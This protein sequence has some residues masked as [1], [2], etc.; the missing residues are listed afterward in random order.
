V[1]DVTAERPR[2]ELE[3]ERD[4]LL[5]S[6]SDLEREHLAGDVD[7]ED[8]ESL[9]ADYVARAAIAIRA[10]ETRP[11]AAERRPTSADRLSRIRRFL[12]RPTTRRSL[13]AVGVVCLLL[14]VGLL[15]A[16]LAGVR[17]PGES[18]TGS[19]SLPRAT[20]IRDDLAAASLFA[21][22]GRQAEAVGLYDA[23]LELDPRQ[24]V[25]LADRGWLERLA[26]LK[27][28]SHKAVLIGDASIALAVAV[29]PGYPDAHA[30]DAV[31]LADD[32][33]DLPAA[34]AQ[35]ASMERDHPS[36]T[37]LSEYGA[38]LAEIDRRAHVVVPRNL[39]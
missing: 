22:S 29:A 14:A 33:H 39:A 5:R 1:G 13:I 7:T 16:E 2:A 10:L 9:R 21:N 34:A 17:L 28:H 12:G 20:Q 4:F 32:A 24:P 15:A 30:Y 19:V 36:A 35:I 25:A 8:Y 26:G 6:I 31:A 3:A 27:A 18:A 38:T 11:A 37:L 23:V